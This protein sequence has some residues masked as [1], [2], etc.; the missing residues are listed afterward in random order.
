M[1]TLPTLLAITAAALIGSQAHAIQ[2]LDLDSSSSDFVSSV[3]GANNTITYQD[4]GVTVT[5]QAWSQLG[6]GSSFTQSKLVRYSSGLGVINDTEGSGSPNHAIDNVGSFDYVYF[7]FDR[8]VDLSRVLIGYISGDSDFQL[9]IGT[10]VTAPSGFFGG[11]EHSEINW[12]TQSSGARWANV[13]G[14]SVLGNSIL[15]GANTDQSENGYEDYFKLR[16][17][18]FDV[19]NVPD[20]SS[21]LALLGLGMISLIAVRRKR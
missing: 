13:N 16:A 14:S 1:K 8:I 21:T 2:Y 3:G 11:F 6:Q 15:I 12:S 19:A 5:A 9:W 20:A 7:S 18:E 17:L 10:D 4:N